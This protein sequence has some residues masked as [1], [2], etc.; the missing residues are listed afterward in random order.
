[1]P[2]YDPPNAFYTEV[3]IPEY[4]DTFKLMGRGGFFMK[5]ITEQSGCQYIWV[6]LE[7]RV[8]EIWG[9][10]NRLGAGIKAVRRRIKN[11]THL[12]TPSEYTQLTCGALKSA[13]DVTCWQQG[14]QIFY[15][16][17]GPSYET[18]TFFGKLLEKF[19]Y[20]PYMTQIQKQV[21]NCLLV[22]RFE[23]CD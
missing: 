16:I 20:I 19:P 14:S 7:R 2:P 5:K 17:R 11:L 23:S 22:S 9:S 3:R 4:V 18:T 8:V 13:I 15:E 10:E 6:D 1:M 12:W 21:T